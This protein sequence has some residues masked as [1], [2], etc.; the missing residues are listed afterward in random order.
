MH[1]WES[2]DLIEMY[3]KALGEYAVWHDT[4]ADVSGDTLAFEE[5]REIERIEVLSQKYRRELKVVKDDEVEKNKILKAME[6]DV[7]RLQDILG[8]HGESG[9]ALKKFADHL[10]YSESSE[11]AAEIYDKAYRMNED[12][13]STTGASKILILK[14]WALCI[15]KVDPNAALQKLELAEKYLDENYM[16]KHKWADR[17]RDAKVK[18]LELVSIPDF[19]Q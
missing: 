12:L 6:Q 10:W 8:N 1:A 14:N 2:E 4:I 19:D 11:K 9:Y 3:N 17:V 13:S 15:K 16:T 7:A 5:I 18:V